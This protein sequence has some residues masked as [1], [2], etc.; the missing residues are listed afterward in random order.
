LP[1]KR[2]THCIHGHPFSEENTYVWAFNGKRMCRTCN[3]ERQASYCSRKRA[4]RLAERKAELD[5]M[6]PQLSDIEL[7]WAAGLFEGEGTVSVLK[8]KKHGYTRPLATVTSTDAEVTAFFHERWPGTLRQIQPKSPRARPAT[9]WQLY[10]S[11]Q[12]AAF[13][14]QIL[15]FIR[16]SRVREKMELVLMDANS[17]V[18]GSRR[19]EYQAVRDVFYE[20]IRLLNRRGRH[21]E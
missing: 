14:E 12:V 15:P 10:S 4:V 8:N 16:T 21:D 9:V 18:R 7:A 2:N 5:A 3:R 11:V 1:P 6:R 13:I 20:N 19:P 17:R